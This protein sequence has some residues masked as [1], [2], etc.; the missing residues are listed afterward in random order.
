MYL[1]AEQLKNL[2]RK[3]GEAEK[4]KIT[5]TVMANETGIA[6]GTIAS[7]EAEGGG[8]KK[9]EDIVQ[10]CKYFKIPIPSEISEPQITYVNPIKNKI[11]IYDIDIAAGIYEMFDDTNNLTPAYYMDI[12]EYYGCKGFRV[13]SNSMAP[14]IT[15]GSI[16]FCKEIQDWNDYIEYG[17]IY[18][19][20]AGEKVKTIKYIRRSKDE[21]KFILRSHNTVEYDDFEIPKKDIKSLWIVEGWQLKKKQ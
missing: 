21:T 18:A 16:I 11:P 15:P 19:I 6:R 20:Y 12:P 9:Y 4:R 10:V 5:Q 1:T 17:E 8:V 2:R 13:Y 3:K 14:L 7:W